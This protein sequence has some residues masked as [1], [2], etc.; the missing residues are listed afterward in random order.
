VRRSLA[1]A[2]AWLAVAA[3]ITITVLIASGT[4]GGT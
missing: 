2:A 1:A 4:W 3:A